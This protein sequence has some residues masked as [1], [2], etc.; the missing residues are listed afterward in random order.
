MRYDPS[1]RYRPLETP[2]LP[3]LII[4]GLIIAILAYLGYGATSAPKASAKI[5]VPLATSSS[6]QAEPN[7]AYFIVNGETLA[8]PI[9]HRPT[10]FKVASR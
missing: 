9:E 7:V 6:S 2:R 8:M 4:G 3:L 5:Y 10:A 1:S